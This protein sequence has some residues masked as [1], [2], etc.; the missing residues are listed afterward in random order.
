[1]ADFRPPLVA[2]RFHR[3]ARQNARQRVEK[4]E[5]FTFLGFTHYC[6]KNLALPSGECPAYSKPRIP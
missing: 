3:F 1:M 5:E 2:R 6:G 4:A